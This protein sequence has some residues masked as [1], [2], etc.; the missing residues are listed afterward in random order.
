MGAVPVSSRLAFR[1][2]RI[3]SSPSSTG[4]TE[5]I[6]D[7][8]GVGVGLDWI[9]LD[10]AKTKV[11]LVWYG[12]VCDTMQCN[13]MR[14]DPMR[15]VELATIQYNTIQYWPNGLEWNGMPR[16]CIRTQRERCGAMRAGAS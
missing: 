9:G 15:H 12:M 2:S 4:R 13:A 11:A 3:E 6:L 16:V 1:M 14:S 8:I 5:Q 10:F 7:W